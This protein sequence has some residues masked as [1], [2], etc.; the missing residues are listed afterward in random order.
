ME[1]LAVVNTSSIFQVSNHQIQCPKTEKKVHIDYFHR[2]F[3]PITCAGKSQNSIRT[4]KAACS[5]AA[6]NVLYAFSIS[7]KANSTRVKLARAH[8][9]RGL[10]SVLNS[11]CVM[12]FEGSS[13]PESASF[14]SIGVVTVS[15][16]RV[17]IA[18]YYQF[19]A[20]GGNRVTHQYSE[21][22]GSP[23]E[24]P[25]SFHEHQ[26]SQSH[27]PEPLTPGRVQSFEE[28][29][30]PQSHNHNPSHPSTPSPSPP[31]PV[32]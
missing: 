26:H 9:P 22:R 29:R 11:L 30:P 13:F 12:S 21:P 3:R 24:G 2:G 17:V 5:A 20:Q 6:P 23:S 32:R 19:P 7:L 8:R 16:N 31:H 25:L 18:V 14:N 28:L 10:N 4:F 1:K 27:H 15:T